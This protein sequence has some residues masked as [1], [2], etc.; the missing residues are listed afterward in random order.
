MHAA[1]CVHGWLL[2]TEGGSQKWVDSDQM[3]LKIQMKLKRV[4]SIHMKFFT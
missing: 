4:P 2:R 3:L 1:L